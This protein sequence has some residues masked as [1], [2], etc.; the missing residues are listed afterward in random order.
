MERLYRVGELAAVTGVT[1]RALHHYDRIGLLRPAAHSEGGHRLYSGQDLLRLQQILTLRFLGFSLQEI[2]ALLERP[3]FSLMASLRI[4]RRV[5][6][7]RA[8]ELEAIGSAIEGLLERRQTNGRWDWDLVA[9]L[10]ARVQR[11]LARK[12]DDMHKHYTPE[13]MQQFDELRQE[14][15]PEEIAA[16]EQGWTA[17]LAE[18]R[19]H[20]DLDPASPKAR[21]LAD[22]WDALTEATMR[23]YR[24]RPELAQAIAENYRQGRFEGNERAPQAADFAFIERVK[25]AR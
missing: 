8:S 15:S 22:R 9:E 14:V 2:G 17:L 5:L 18:V 10:S 1:I 25:Q 4:Q 16:I 7:D 3:D 24:S 21:E 23:H 11:R 13:Q 19:A 6:R 12:G 20:R